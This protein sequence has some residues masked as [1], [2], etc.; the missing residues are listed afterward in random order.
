M[1]RVIDRYV[2]SKSYWP[3]I[4]NHTK[5][6]EPATWCEYESEW[7]Q[8]CINHHNRLH[9]QRCLKKKRTT[10]K[11]SCTGKNCKHVYNV[12]HILVEKTHVHLLNEKRVNAISTPAGRLIGL[13]QERRNDRKN[14]CCACDGCAFP[15]SLAHA[16][17]YL[18]HFFIVFRVFFT[19][20]T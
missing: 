6:L 10:I 16:R 19:T 9:S 4:T 15:S 14:I 18:D 5:W 2:G 13:I 12:Q 8:E 1:K 20:Q 17:T 11:I 3:M 7:I